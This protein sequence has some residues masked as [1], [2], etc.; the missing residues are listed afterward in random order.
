[1][2]KHVEIEDIDEL[3]RRVG[4]YDVQLREEIRALRPGDHVRLT[5]LGG[6]GPQAGQ[7]LRVRIT[8]IRGEEFR[9]KLVDRPATR[10]RSGL[11]AGSAIAF[12]ASH[13]HSIAGRPRPTQRG[14]ESP[15]AR[16]LGSK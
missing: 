6:P 5:L 3:R 10:A 7:T 11:D 8:R 14:L 9:G 4:I 13:I 2:A 12:T 16:K 15:V 1:M